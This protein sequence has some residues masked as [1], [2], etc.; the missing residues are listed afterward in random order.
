MLEL[1][2]S[3]ASIASLVNS[4]VSSSDLA[5]SIASRAVIILVV[6]AGYHFLFSFFET[7]I[8][9]VARSITTA[10]FALIDGHFGQGA[11]P[12]AKTVFILKAGNNI[13]IIKNKTK[14]LFIYNFFITFSKT[15]VQTIPLHLTIE[16]W[17]FQGLMI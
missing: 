12:L 13:I 6:L 14:L 1:P 16:M 10:S 7:R 5:C 17:V 8:V 15:I 3:A 9:P 11:V 2:R 4:T